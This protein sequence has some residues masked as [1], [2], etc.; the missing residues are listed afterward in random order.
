MTYD[1]AVQVVLCSHD[2][3]VVQPDT[4]NR[5]NIKTFDQP[6][7]QGFYARFAQPRVERTSKQIMQDMQD[8]M[9]ARSNNAVRRDVQAGQSK[10]YVS[11]MGVPGNE[12]AIRVAREEWFEE[13]NSPTVASVENALEKKY[14]TPTRVQPSGSQL[15]L[16]WAFDPAGALIADGSPLFNVCHG[17]ADPDGPSHF[18][19][20][21]G[22]VVAASVISTRNNPDIAQFMQVGIVDQALGYAQITG[23]EQELQ[24][25]EAQ[26]R[27]KE[28]EA[29][30]KNSTA[31]KL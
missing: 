7:R 11:T 29:A 13:A 22:V 5:F 27:A 15:T 24:R 19:P 25:L 3:L 10:W 17:M 14:G 21:C 4:S 28:V 23:T 20:E 30:S 2:L 18:S 26:R 16:T 6:V 1:A 12:T 31:P 8:D 9:M